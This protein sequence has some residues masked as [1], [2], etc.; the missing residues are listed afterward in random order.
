MSPFPLVAIRDVTL[1]SDRM[2]IYEFYCSDCHRI[3][4]FLS[5][6]VAAA[7]RP[8]CPRCGKS[9]L[10]RRVSRFAISRGRAEPDADGMPDIDEAR[11]EQAMA[12]MAGEAEKIN[13]DDPRQM[14]GL[15][16]RLY[17][18]TGLQLGPGMEEA[19]R[20]MEAGEDPDQVEQELGDALEEEDPFALG[21]QRGLKGLRRRFRPPEVDDTLYEM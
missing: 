19:I 21:E 12:S 15:M 4:N 1:H 5:R 14:A 3:F 20:R 10:E 8:A 9:R 2:P 16:R 13:E 7:R 18:A 17:D 11:L 6:K